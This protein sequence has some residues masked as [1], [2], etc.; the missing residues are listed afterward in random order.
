MGQKLLTRFDLVQPTR[1]L[2]GAVVDLCY[3]RGCADCGGEVGGEPLG[4][5]VCDTCRESYRGVPDV[6]GPAA[7]ARA[8]TLGERDLFCRRCGSFAARAVAAPDGTELAP[9]RCR[10]CEGWKRTG[11][12]G[13]IPLGR[14]DDRLRDAVLRMKSSAGDGLSVA[15]ADVLWQVRGDMIRRV[16]ADVIVPV[17]MHRWRRIMRGASSAERLAEQLGKNW[18]IPM[19]RR[20]LMRRRNTLAQGGLTPDGRHRNVAG[21]FRSAAGYDLRGLR[22]VLV[23]DVLTTGA[24]ANEAARVLRR[25]GAISVQAVVVARTEHHG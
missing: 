6:R 7:T 5:V 12:D 4:P 9:Q 24:T 8:S 23:D 16:T 18:G 3:P 11:I 22:V 2:V 21:A 20:M 13:V 10:S 19:H 15:M 14:Y 1:R 25:A 17:P